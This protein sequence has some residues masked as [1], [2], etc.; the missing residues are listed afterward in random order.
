MDTFTKQPEEKL[1]YTVDFSQALNTG[2]SLSAT[3]PTTSITKITTG[4]DA[5]PP[6]LG[7]A[8]VNVSAGSVKQM[9]SNGSDGFV[10]MYSC[11]ATTADGETIE[12]NFKLK[13]KDY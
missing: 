3:A 5:S 2:D 8:I 13:V 12:G 4:T 1:F 10:Y 9:I 11:I 7:A 6:T